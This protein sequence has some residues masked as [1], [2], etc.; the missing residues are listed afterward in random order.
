MARGSSRTAAGGSFRRAGAG[1]HRPRRPDAAGIA[2]P[3]E[4]MRR[5]LDEQTRS[6]ERLRFLVE[7]SK[8]LN[9]TLDLFE[10]LQLILKMAT[11]QTGA[12]RGTLFLVDR[13]KAEAWSL[14][15]QGL[16]RREIRLP[17]GR[18]IAGWVAQTGATANLPDVAHDPRFDA[19]FDARFGYR[20]RSLLALPIRDRSGRTVGVLELLNKL[21]G[22][23]TEV[24]VDFLE[25]ISVHA[26]IAIENAR[27]YRESLERQRLDDELAL[28]HRI[29]QGLLPEAPP[30]L[31]G[32]DIA[33]RHETCSHVGGDYYD[34]IPLSPTA[35]LIVVADVEGKGAS[36]A[37]VASSVHATLHALARHVHSL[38]GIAFHLND[39]V[40]RHTRGGRYLTMFLG[41][42][43]VPRRAIHFINAGHVPPLLIG[44]EHTTPL[45]EGGCV[46]G[47]FPRARFQRGICWLEPGDVLL[48]CTDG[49]TETP[50]GSAEEYGADRLAAAGAKHRDRPAAEIVDAICADVCRHA[51]GSARDDRVVMAIRAA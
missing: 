47:L 18:G 44:R 28:A 42:V 36:S 2:D 29:Q 4:T 7:A 10:L 21:D 40:Y 49:L 30:R 15:A 20:T 25:G 9:S 12:D 1:S 51:A 8:V 14:I 13:E 17:I 46:L 24:D 31:P 41:L 48:A 19:E 27:L 39:A 32:L 43:D 45:S 22:P 37:L 50:D 35:Q 33:V 5:A 34:F 26:A 16:D 23:F 6:L 11:Q 38:E 3:L